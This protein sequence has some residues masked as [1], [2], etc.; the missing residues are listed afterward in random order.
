MYDDDSDAPQEN[1]SDDV[2]YQSYDDAEEAMEE[3]IWL[4]D[5]GASAHMSM[6]MQGLYELRD[7]VGT[8]TVGNEAKL[9]VKKI[10]T[11]VG[12]VMQKDGQ[13]KNIVLKNVKYVPKLKCNLLS[14][15][16]AINCGFEMRDNNEGLWI[17]K[18]AMTYDFD[19]KYKSVSGFLF[20][21]KIDNRQVRTNVKTSARDKINASIMHAR[22][23]HTDETYIRETCKRLGVDIKRPFPSCEI[24]AISKMKQKG[25]QKRLYTKALKKGERLFMNI[26]HVKGESSGDFKY[27]LLVVDEATE[28]QW[29]FFPQCEETDEK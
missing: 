11:K 27:W 9:E 12:T 22:L 29:S 16:Q 17:R 26:S 24:C 18:G 6:S 2:A 14:L 25:T 15:T 1:L 4:G 20:G 5:T 21:L 3:S 23:G 13:H 7:Y 19:R 10:G 28:F 8:V